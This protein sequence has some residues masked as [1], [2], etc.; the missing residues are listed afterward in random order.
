M[1][2]ISTSSLKKFLD[3]AT[4][5]KDNNLLPIYKYVK[6]D[7]NGG[8]ATG[9]KSNGHSFCIVDMGESGDSEC[10]VINEQTLRVAVG[11]CTSGL[12]TI[13]QKKDDHAV[14]DTGAQRFSATTQP[15]KHFPSIQERSTTDEKFLF[16]TDVIIAIASAKNHTAPPVDKAM[17]M[18]SCYVNTF[19]FNK[20]FYVSGTNGYVTYFKSF[21]DKLPKVSLEPE[22]ISVISKYNS[23]FYLRVG[24]Y[25]YFD[26]GEVAYGFIKTETDVPN[27]SLI[28][29]NMK[30]NQSFVINK[31]RVID[32]CE[33]S[34]AINQASVP[35]EVCISEKDDSLFFSAVDLMGAEGVQ[36]KIKPSEKNFD[37][38]DFSFQ[39]K[40]MITVLKSVDGEEVKLSYTQHNMIVTSKDDQNYI[41]SIMGLAPIQKQ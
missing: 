6:I 11:V 10:I 27:L 12:I 7:C 14:I 13:E 22:V 29:N 18:W 28:I 17:R 5:I 25:D 39:P 26:T 20:K 16:S 9:Y 24:N 41:G 8:H 2:K 34:I 15:L 36:D 19:E 4:N 3:A 35:T 37:M 32:F 33:S 31:K 40:Y 1:I 38:E 23:M 21:S 30:S